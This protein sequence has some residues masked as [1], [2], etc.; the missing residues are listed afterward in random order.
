MIEEI[1]IV[2]R[3]IFNSI[4]ITKVLKPLSIECK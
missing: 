2:A 1:E 4:T 3:L